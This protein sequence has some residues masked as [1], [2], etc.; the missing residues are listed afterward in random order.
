MAKNQIQLARFL[1]H[2]ND[3]AANLLSNHCQANEVVVLESLANDRHLRIGH[4]ED[5]KQF[6]L[7]ARFYTE[8]KV[9]TEINVLPNNVR[10]RGTN[11]FSGE[12]YMTVLVINWTKFSVS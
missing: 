1:N 4:G 8:A 12:K 2:G 5:G 11:I 3:G 7:A 9:A 6:R 10:L